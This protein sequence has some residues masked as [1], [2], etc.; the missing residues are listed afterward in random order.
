M[1]PPNSW[2]DGQVLPIQICV[3]L[4]FWNAAELHS[5]DWL[6]LLGPKGR[7]KKTGCPMDSGMH[8]LWSHASMNQ[9]NFLVFTLLSRL[10]AFKNLMFIGF[11]LIYNV[12]FLIRKIRWTQNSWWSHASIGWNR[13]RSVQFPLHSCIIQSY[14]GKQ[15]RC[16]RL[17]Q[18]GNRH[19]F[20]S[21]FNSFVGLKM[22]FWQ[23]RHKG[24]FTGCVNIV[25]PSENLHTNFKRI[26][27]EIV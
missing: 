1:K 3:M 19:P 7:R 23:T 9:N 8:P 20:L 2:I 11:S 25:L 12:A 16:S 21:F 14:N 24:L 18:N 6:G 10:F 27:K 4:L 13:R 17:T 5:T 22:L 26:V 15:I